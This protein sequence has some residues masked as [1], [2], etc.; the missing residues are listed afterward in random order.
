M[1]RGCRGRDRDRRNLADLDESLRRSAHEHG[2]GRYEPGQTTSVAID[3]A[4][5]RVCIAGQETVQR[6]V[7]WSAQDE[8]AD[9][10]KAEPEK[11]DPA[12]ARIHG[13]DANAQAA[14]PQGRACN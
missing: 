5:A 4:V 12:D 6:V 11:D 7:R 14:G 3:P 2:L 10:Q 9:E 8:P 1:E 13:D